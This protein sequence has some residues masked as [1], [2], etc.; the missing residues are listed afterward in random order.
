MNF[1]SHEGKKNTLQY[2]LQQT[3][4]KRFMLKNVN[5]TSYK[6]FYFECGSSIAHDCDSAADR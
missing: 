4:T 6:H 3:H 5:I 2:S 1:S